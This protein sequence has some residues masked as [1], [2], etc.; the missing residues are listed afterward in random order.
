MDWWRLTC[1]GY[2]FKAP[3]PAPLP[4]KDLYLSFTGLAIFVLFYNL[5][6]AFVFVRRNIDKITR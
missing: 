3:S 4:K 1:F 6:E 5:N 2:L